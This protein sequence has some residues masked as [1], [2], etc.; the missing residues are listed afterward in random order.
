MDEEDRYTRI[1]LRIPKELH[2]TLGEHAE[3]TAKSLNAEIVGRLLASVE[4]QPH[5][6]NDEATRNF[7]RLAE[8]ESHLRHSRGELFVMALIVKHATRVLPKE[9]SPTDTAF[10]AKAEEKADLLIELLRDD[11]SDPEGI[12]RRLTLAANLLDH[13]ITYT[14]AREL[15]Q[16][17][18]WQSFVE[19]A[20]TVRS[21][22]EKDR[23]MLEEAYRAMPGF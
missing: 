6:E 10:F 5:T 1:T 9:L 3:A 8:L 2:R 15:D 21:H 23:K 14:G 7:F 4:K 17:E 22:L 12:R 19:N 20:V 11:L 13:T 18:D 16:P